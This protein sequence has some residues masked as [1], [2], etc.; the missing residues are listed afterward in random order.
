MRPAA[1]VATLLALTAVGA[2][3]AYQTAARE[4]DYRQ[5][6]SR[7]DAARAADQAFAAIEAYSGAIVLRPDAMLPYLRRGE[8]YALRGDLDAAARDFRTAAKLDSSAMRPLEEL[9]DV[10]YE[11]QRFDAAAETY[12]RRLRLDDR[13]PGVTYK[14]ALARYRNGNIDGALRAAADTIH[15]NDRLASAYY[16]RGLCLREKYHTTEAVEAFERAATL[17]PGMIPAREELADLYAE[18]GRRADTLEQLQ[19]LAGLN[20]R[21]ERQIAVGLAHARLGHTDLAVL[22]LG[23]ALDRTPDQP[24]IYAALGRV[25]LDMAAS[26]SDA[27]SKALQ[28][29]ERAASAP[30][31]TSEVL[32]LYGRALLKA[33]RAERA[34]RILQQ[35]TERFPV[36]PSAYSEYAT[37]AELQN[38]LEAARN[39]LLAHAALVPDDGA[40]G[41][42][43][44]KI[45]TLSLKLNDRGTAVTWLVRAAAA[46]P[47]DSLQ[48][49]ALADAQLRAGDRTAAL[50]T[51]NRGLDRDPDNSALIEVS[52]RA[53]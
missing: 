21:V 11:R 4:R 31:T 39:A 15:L 16:L 10:L 49:A 23:A 52:Q 3:V 37:A 40:S 18:L 30:S 19:L 9:G 51:I 8:A 36:D 25:W 43:A 35:A 50:N 27:L 44:L 6:L 22:A 1:A 5:Q 2:A 24:L 34:E 14:L 13:S 53:R 20:G 12:E 26:R 38:H 33:N 41:T 47:S 46:T 45:A 28:A 7:G 42:R 32:T 17:S 48:L 29:L